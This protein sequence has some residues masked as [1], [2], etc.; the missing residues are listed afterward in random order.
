MDVLPSRFHSFPNFRGKNPPTSGEDLL[1]VTQTRNPQEAILWMW[2]SNTILPVPMGKHLKKW[3]GS[4]QGIGE[5]Q[6]HDRTEAALRK[7]RRS[8][9]HQ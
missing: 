3:G 9:V 6:G 4:G 8:S 5:V 1:K 2:L 7:Q